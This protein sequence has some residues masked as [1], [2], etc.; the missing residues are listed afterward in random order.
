MNRQRRRSSAIFW[1]VGFEALLVGA[2]RA[3]AAGGRYAVDWGSPWVWLDQTAPVDAVVAIA[4]TVGL[5]LS[6]YLLVTTLLYAWAHVAGWTGLARLLRRATLPVVRKAVEGVAA[7]SI[8]TSTLTAPVLVAASPAFAQESQRVVEDSAVESDPAA[9]PVG[10]TPVVGVDY[11]P[12]AAGW[13][14]AGVGDGLWANVGTEAPAEASHAVVRGDHFWSIAESHLESELGRSVTEDEVCAYWAR[15]VDANRS[16]IRSGDP[17]L[18]FPGEV[19]TLVPV[20]ADA[21]TN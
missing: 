19:I 13:P 18:I 14:V 11:S 12:E 9:N 10:E 16:T 7:V 20:F 4:R 21:P 6:W 8:V 5:G 15:L 3:A 17:N 1:V 2:F